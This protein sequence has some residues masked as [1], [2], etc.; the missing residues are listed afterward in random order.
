MSKPWYIEVWPGPELDHIATWIQGD[1]RNSGE[2]FLYDC[3]GFFLPMDQR[4]W[5]HF[6][7]RP[8]RLMKEMKGP[9]FDV[10]VVIRNYCHD[11]QHRYICL[12]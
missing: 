1:K 3:Y 6:I 11:F 10:M 7:E 4:T 2:F 9:D 8:F 5:N 12:N